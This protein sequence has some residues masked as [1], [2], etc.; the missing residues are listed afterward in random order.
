MKTTDVNDGLDLF[1]ETLEDD[2]VAIVSV[3]DGHVFGFKRAT[4]QAMLD[5]NPDNEKF[6]VFVKTRELN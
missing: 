6:V 5:Q 2:G 1:N 4:L 3:S